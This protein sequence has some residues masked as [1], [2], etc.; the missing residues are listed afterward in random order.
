MD[1]WIEQIRKTR[2]LQ[3]SR[4]CDGLHSPLL[5]SQPLQVSQTYVEMEF[6]TE[7]AH[8]R[9]LD[10]E[11]L[12]ELFWQNTADAL[13]SL[14]P[15]A[16]LPLN[17]VI[18]H[19]SR[20][21]VIGSIG[22]GKTTLLKHLALQCN[23]GHF[24]PH[25]IPLLITLRNLSENQKTTTFTLKNYIIKQLTQADITYEQAEIVLQ[26]GRVQLFLDGLDEVAFPQ[27][28]A[29]EICTLCQQFP[30]LPIIIS[31]RAT[32]IEAQ[33]SGFRYVEIADFSDTQIKKFA[34]QWFDRYGQSE[35][36]LSTI[37]SAVRRSQTTIV[38]AASPVSAYFVRAVHHQSACRQHTDR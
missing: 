35:K 3:V 26:A 20:L 14:T 5:L 4:Q 10:I 1:Q 2:F 13:S 31:H 36:K 34:R 8:Q 11:A 32:G 23:A 27:R 19:T 28:I 12:E 22:T 21:V 30:N 6:T 16:R 29:Q 18:E 9:W 38:E 33:F 24:Q 17:A 37:Y 25:C 15:T 7:L